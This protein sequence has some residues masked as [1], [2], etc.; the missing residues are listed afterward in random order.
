MDRLGGIHELLKTNKRA[1]KNLSIYIQ[2]LQVKPTKQCILQ[3]PP[4]NLF[5]SHQI[6]PTKDT[7]GY[8][9][10]SIIHLS[11]ISPFPQFSTICQM[12]KATLTRLQFIYNA[13]C[14]YAISGSSRKQKALTKCPLPILTIALSS[15]SQFPITISNPFVL[16]QTLLLFH[17]CHH[18]MIPLCTYAEHEGQ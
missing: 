13:N 10:I 4:P 6:S 11:S 7:V 12:K 9:T 2:L 15:Q 1:R 18:S 16:L 3:V 14:M 17:S 5:C 8:N